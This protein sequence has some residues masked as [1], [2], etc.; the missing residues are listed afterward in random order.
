MSDI[1]ALQSGKGHT[2]EN[3]PVASFL[4]AP[5]HRAPIL[6]FYK[7]VR[8]A[9]DVAD[10]PTAAPDTKLALL[11]QM[12]AGLAGESDTSPEGVALKQTLDARGL[13]PEHAFDLL[14]AF[15]RDV[16]KLRYRD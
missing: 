12:R 7:F 3:F 8:A 6:A 9:D 16:T 15:R 10:H 2:D 1:A 5:R 13:S 4:I 14:E 11:E